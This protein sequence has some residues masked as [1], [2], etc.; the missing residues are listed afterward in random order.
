M[1]LERFV[2]T[3]LEDCGGYVGWLFIQ[4]GILIGEVF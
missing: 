3:Y 1:M 4:F 2:G